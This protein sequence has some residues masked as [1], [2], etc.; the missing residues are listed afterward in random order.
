MNKIENKNHIGDFGTKY[1]AKALS[2]LIK[3]TYL[4]LAKGRKISL[5]D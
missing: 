3:L 5:L 1:L 4:D 2:Y